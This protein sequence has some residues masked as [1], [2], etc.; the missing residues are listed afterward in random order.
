V[1]AYV[2]RFIKNAKAPSLK[3]TGPL[4]ATELYNVQRLWIQTAQQEVFAKEFRQ[5][6]PLDYH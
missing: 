3:A 5:K 6:Q 1:T 4:T 2:L